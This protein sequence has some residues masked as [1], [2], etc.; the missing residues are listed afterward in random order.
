[1]GEK[2]KAIEYRYVCPR[3]GAPTIQ[4]VSGVSECARADCDGWLAPN[5]TTDDG[6][7]RESSLVPQGA[8][9][10]KSGYAAAERRMNGGK[11]CVLAKIRV[12]RVCPEGHGVSSVHPINP[13]TGRCSADPQRVRVR[14]VE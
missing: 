12:P 2:P 9:W 14:L 4:N 5:E 13:K 1:M 3:C 7:H 8:F 11:D 6:E 10:L